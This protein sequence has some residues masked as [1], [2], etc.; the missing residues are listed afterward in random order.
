MAISVPHC[1][2]NGSAKL[3]RGLLAV[4]LARDAATLRSNCAIA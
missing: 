2:R 3:R 4:I 1:S